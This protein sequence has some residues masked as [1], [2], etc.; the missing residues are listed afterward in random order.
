MSKRK[1][2]KVA[3]PFLD[4]PLVDLCYMVDKKKLPA[5]MY[6]A[7]LRSRNNY[8]TYYFYRPTP[9][10]FRF[11]GAYERGL[12]QDTLLEEGDKLFYIEVD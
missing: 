6:H 5:V 1:P 11:E 7:P 10:G 2:K 12:V 8:S 3:L 4:G 9:E